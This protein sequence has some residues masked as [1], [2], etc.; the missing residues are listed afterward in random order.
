MNKLFKILTIGGLFFQLSL[1][2]SQQCEDVE[3]GATGRDYWVDSLGNGWRGE[4][5]KQIQ[6]KDDL[7]EKLIPEFEFE[8]NDYLA[9][10]IT[11]EREVEDF[12]P[13]PRSG[14]IASDD[15]FRL[16]IKNKFNIEVTANVN[17]PFLFAGGNA[18]VSLAHTS[19][20]FPGKDISACELYSEIL[21]KDTEE[22][23]TFYESV[24]GQ[25][26]KL[27]FTKWY[28]SG[29][30]LISS[31]FRLGLNYLVDSEKNKLFTKNLM[32]PLKI[33]S[34][35]GIPLDRD[36]F[37]ENNASLN[38]GDILEHT[39][40]FG[41]TPGGL[42]VNFFD[43]LKPSFSK[44]AR[45]FRTV[46]FRK[47]IKNQ[48]T[49]EFEDVV[50]H[51]EDTTIY[52][53]RPKI[54]K[55][56]KLNIGKWSFD[57]YKQDR[58][59]QRF[60][61]DLNHELGQKFFDEILESMNLYIPSFPL[62]P[63]KILI[64]ASAYAGGVV[65][66]SPIHTDSKGKDNV[67]AINIPGLLK[68]KN[69]THSVL[70]NI[71][72]NEVRKHEDEADSIEERKFM[73]GE[74]YFVESFKNKIGLN[75][76]LF[77]IKKADKNFDCNMKLSSDTSVGY[78]RDSSMNISCNYYNRFSSNT[79][80]RKLIEYLDMVSFDHINEQDRKLLSSINYEERD[81]LNMYSNLS[82]SKNNIENILNARED[83]IYHLIA[84]LFFGPKAKNIFAKKYHKKWKSALVK[85]Q[86]T[87]ASQRDHKK[88]SSMNSC[89]LVLKELGITTS[90][91][92]EILYDQFNGV[93]GKAKGFDGLEYYR[94]YSYYLLAKETVESI[95]KLQIITSN[96]DQL[97]EFLE[98]FKDL[99][100]VGF[101]QAV[102][103]VLG[104]GIS[105]EN[106]HFTYLISS[107]HLEEILIS[108]NGN[109]Y[110]V[111]PPMISKTLA[112][113]VRSELRPR[114]GNVKFIHNI[115]QP[116]IIMAILKLNYEPQNRKN[117]Y[118]KFTLADFSYIKD[119]AIGEYYFSFDQMIRNTQGEY[120]AR[121][122][123][124]KPLQIDS[125]HT[126][127]VELM[128]ENDFRL[129]REIK[130]YLKKPNVSF[131]NLSI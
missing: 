42:Q 57:D 119:D 18:G 34:N 89:S 20:N 130:V 120:I 15:F 68:Y 93:V 112:S 99:N 7:F 1:A 72:Y 129:S 83:D 115:C 79:T 71:S 81:I 86:M 73:N 106:V 11:F 117:L 82:F 62:G 100:Q 21:N 123:L 78:E 45:I 127:Y 16:Q 44:Y 126:M 108:S 101:V 88:L 25:R 98:I 55:Y 76:G 30:D 58:V 65:T 19:Y 97:G 53:I 2:L 113:E 111:E 29:V 24:C 47:E 104:G 48:V 105:R 52:K 109:K 4:F 41:I 118:G 31:A 40:Y 95:K 27:F 36:I 91:R 5:E 75:L 51:G 102:L 59:V 64:N 3:L 35:L 74:K 116:D 8:F 49:V 37:Y 66:T 50:I 63:N 103:A 131:D 14:K 87:I 28:E 85:K 9:A 17:G 90:G 10:K 110:E 107:P 61:V 22:G 67:L 114:I 38:I 94:C 96:R 128:N 56:L 70:E 46:S 77:Q 54:L 13:R 60:I 33:H 92:R 23:Q 43:V 80:V 84:K 26:D 122:Q 32:D 6:K 69:E 125:A 124:A 39:T 121:I 12:L